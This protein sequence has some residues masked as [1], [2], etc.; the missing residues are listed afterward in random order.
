MSQSWYSATSG[1]ARYAAIT[2]ASAVV[3]SRSVRRA[4]RSGRTDIATFNC[5]AGL[6]FPTFSP[7]E[8]VFSG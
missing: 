5:P 7:G 4:V 6:D 3:A 2:G 8:Q 1:S